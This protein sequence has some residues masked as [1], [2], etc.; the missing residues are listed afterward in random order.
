LEK[1]Q[2]EIDKESKDAL[3]ALQS[4]PVGQG[5]LEIDSRVN[6]SAGP[7]GL[8]AIEWAKFKVD[9]HVPCNFDVV[10]CAGISINREGCSH[11]GWKLN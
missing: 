2:A 3:G 7:D 5:G 4:F 9:L 11:G 10:G 8:G 6:K 1:S